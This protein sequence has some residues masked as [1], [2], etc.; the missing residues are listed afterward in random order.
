M[1][2]DIAMTGPSNQEVEGSG[3]K[4]SLITSASFSPL[5][6]KIY[7]HLSLSLAMTDYELHT[8]YKF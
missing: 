7:F 3:L 6:G 4:W 2:A 8:G 1:I 5:Y